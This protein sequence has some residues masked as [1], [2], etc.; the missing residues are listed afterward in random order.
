[1]AGEAEKLEKPVR[2][3]RIPDSSDVSQVI[4]SLIA[5]FYGTDPYIVGT[6]TNIC[7]SLAITARH[8]FEE[9]Q[10]R[11]GVQRHQSPHSNL[12]AL[13]RD[14]SGNAQLWHVMRAYVCPHTDI[15]FLHLSEKPD[16]TMEDYSH[17]WKSP[18]LDAFPPDVNTEVVGFGYRKSAISCT[19]RPCGG[20]HY[21]INDELIQ[22]MGAVEEIHP[23][24]RDKSLS[25]PCFRVTAKFDS[26][27]SGGP[28]FSAKGTV[29]G[30]ICT[31]YDLTDPEEIPISYVSTLWPM[32]E[33]FVQGP[34]FGHYESHDVFRAREL[35]RL[36]RIKVRDRMD[37][38]NW[39]DLRLANQ[40][41]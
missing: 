35:V 34:V 4:Y 29:C 36:D 38:E 41:S 37:L 24:G 19:V 28:V 22:T 7:G 26:G 33:A 17:V 16:S 30:I 32:F 25:W 14:R 3:K 27:M 21:D 2:F 40:G 8:V 20:K 1:M 18:M 23:Q 31:G 39:L 9:I 10:S 5:G 13:Q 6:A 12:M 11:E 15:V